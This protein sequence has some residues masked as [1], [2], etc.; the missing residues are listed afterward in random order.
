MK[1]WGLIITL[2]YALLWMVLVFPLACICLA[3][4]WWLPNF[5][6]DWHFFDAG[7]YSEP[8]FW[9]VW[10]LALICQALLVEAFAERLDNRRRILRFAGVLTFLLANLLYWLV[11]SA[12]CLVIGENFRDWFDEWQ[13]LL[14]RTIE[15]GL[16]R[17]ITGSS[18]GIDNAIYTVAA[19]LILISFFWMAIGWFCYS[20]YRTANWNGLAPQMLSN[21]FRL[22]LIEFLCTLALQFGFSWASYHHAAAISF[23]GAAFGL[24][25]MVMCVGPGALFLSLNRSQQFVTAEPKANLA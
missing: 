22:A 25:I 2:I 16:F 7:F 19:H 13:H 20:R 5:I 21:L 9:F 24:A 23:I 12:I 15:H 17:L 11:L 18:P 10:L 8:L 4:D 3:Y 6:S 1:S 14:R